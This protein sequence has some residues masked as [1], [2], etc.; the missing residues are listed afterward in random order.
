LGIPSDALLIGHVARM[1]PWKGQ[2]YLLEAFGR[3]ARDVPRAQLL[4]V[5]SPVFDTDAFEHG[6]R[7][8]AVALGL[9]GRVHFAGHRRD[10]PQVL[11]AMDVLAYPSVEKDNC[12]LALLEAMA[13]GLPTVAFDIDGVRLVVSDPEYGLLVPVKQIDPLAG[14]LVRVLTD[15]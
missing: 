15:D 3:L 8:R 6:L 5:G 10:I 7:D 13:A 2:R 4:F 1:T 12:P 14:A 11:A 9:A